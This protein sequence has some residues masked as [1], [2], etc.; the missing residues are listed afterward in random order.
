[1]IPRRAI[2]VLVVV[3]L[4]VPLAVCVLLAVA[5]LLA[6]MGD[7]AGRNV[8]RRLAQAGLILWAID[9]AVLVVAVALAQLGPPE[10][11]E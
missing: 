8:V 2:L 1:L 6:A 11:R 10:P 3:G 5:A 9:L 4:V 7:E